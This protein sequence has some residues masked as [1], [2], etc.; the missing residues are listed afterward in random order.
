MEYDFKKEGT[1]GY[2]AFNPP[3]LDFYVIRDMEK[4][5]IGQFESCSKIIFNMEKIDFIASAFI[6]LCLEALQR[7]GKENFEIVNANS[8]VK[9]VLH[10]SKFDNFVKVSE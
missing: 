1:T 9:T 5:L 10:I 3:R 8:F 6:R 4:Q 2:F 7:V